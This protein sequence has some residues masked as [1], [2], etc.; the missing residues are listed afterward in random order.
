LKA[1]ALEKFSKIDVWIN[2]AAVG[3]FG[4][5]DETPEDV[6]RSVVETDF[7]G[8]VNGVSAILPYFKDEGKGTIIN[9]ASAAAKVPQ[10][11]T[12]AVSAS[13]AAVR[14]LGASLR[15][16]L[17]LDK[18][19][20]INVCTVMPASVD[21]P[22]VQ[23][24]ANY[25]GRTTKA[26]EPV[27]KPEQVAMAIVSLIQHPRAEVMVGNAGRMMAAERTMMPGL[28]ESL[29]ARF[30][31]RGHLTKEPQE[32][33]HGNVFEPM[34]E[35][36]G[37]TGGWRQRQQS[38]QVWKQPMAIGSAVAGIAVAGV[39]LLLTT[40]RKRPMLLGR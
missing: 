7:F 13:K 30:V 25:A 23:H 38:R 40:R 4:K 31:D 24:S 27:Y 5:F 14:S 26:L 28:F 35:V 29:Y 37:V 3:A 8:Y 17:K 12:S 10:P 2:D 18:L 34:S 22:W 9:V 1:K 11:Y 33:T 39:V 32:L 21:T 36:G 16:E 15:M 6:F 20:R 19:D